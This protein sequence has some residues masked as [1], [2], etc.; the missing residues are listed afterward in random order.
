MIRKNDLTVSVVTSL[1]VIISGGFCLTTGAQSNE[2]LGDAAR[3]IRGDKHQSAGQLP[4]PRPASEQRSRPSIP[5]SAN[6]SEA[7]QQLYDRGEAA[8]YNA[9]YVSAEKQFREAL[10][11]AAQHNLG[12]NTIAHSNDAV[13]W[14]LRAQRK[15]GDAEV[16][17][18][19]AL[20]MFRSSYSD[21]DEVVAHSKAGLGMA[22]TGLGRYPEAESLLLESLNAY[23]QQPRPTLCALSYPL[24]GL[25]RLYKS[26]YQYSKGEQIYTEV[27]ALM[28][29]DRGTPCENFISLLEHLAE[30][31]ADDNQWDRVEKIQQGRAGLALGMKGPRSEAYG[32]ALYAMADTLH[33]RRRYEEAASAY[34]KAAEVFRHVQPAM[35]SKL[36]LS[37]Q[38]QELSLQ[39]AGKVEEAKQIHDAMLAATRASNA[40]DRHGE[41]MSIHSRAL[42]ARRAGNVEEAAQLIE[43]EVAL[44]QKLTANDQVIALSDAAMIH[45]EQH[46]LAEAEADLK[47]ILELS[48]AS[49]GSSSRATAKAH[50]DLAGFYSRNRRLAEAEEE[51]AAAL[52]LFQAHDTEDVK[53]VLASLGWT[54]VT[55]GK[56]DQAQA[57]YQRAMKLAED[58]HD[59]AGL[60]S[61]LQNLAIVYQKTNRPSDAEA[62]LTRALNLVSQLPRPLNRQWAGVA[63]TAA[64][65]YEQ[66]G[67]PLQAEQ[68]YGR[69][70]TF[71]EQ[72]MG[73]EAP[74]LRLPLD[75]LIAMLKS[76]GRFG[77]AAKYEAR[78]D[79]LPPMPAMPGMAQ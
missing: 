75:K 50:V 62:A 30:L 11:Y 28:T 1:I 39:L 56:F 6:D 29:G 72:E 4:Q 78:R 71:L 19:S 65:F 76:Q 14:S 8:M 55:D 22:L 21:N 38:L 17:Y 12:T 48:I 37:L 16:F 63:L 61:I 13:G 67:R 54:Y 7:W 15:Y 41:T 59:D 10:G 35:P 74:A 57:V 24:D 33:K 26:N 40:E 66:S 60:S 25:T 9:D 79:K 31:Y 27:F 36:A 43:R 20:Q 68:V 77:E 64:S 46:K 53:M 34:A 3:R 44:A 23:H 42:E 51:Y 47:R 45:Q 52:V 73:A 69:L 70:I 49:T 58:T 18:R 32:D 2:S 5:S